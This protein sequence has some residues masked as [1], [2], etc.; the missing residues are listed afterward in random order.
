MPALLQRL[1][2]N[3]NRPPGQT[4]LHKKLPV[5]YPPA[6][7]KAEYVYVYKGK[8]T[9]LGR[10]ADGPFPIRERLGKSCLTVEAGH[11]K[12][13]NPRIELH[14]WRRCVPVLDPQTIEQRP[15]LGRKSD[16]S[17]TIVSSYA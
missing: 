8:K 12:N 15:M 14:H 6:A 9:P 1:K 13:G 3:A 10:L 16:N 7:E 17:D 2:H 11:Y 5:Y 4:A